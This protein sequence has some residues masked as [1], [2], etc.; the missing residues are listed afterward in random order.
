MYDLGD[1]LPLG[2]NS[3]VTPKNELGQSYFLSLDNLQKPALVGPLQ[4][5]LTSCKSSGCM[6]WHN[7]LPRE[8]VWRDYVFVFLLILL[9]VWADLGQR[10]LTFPDLD[11]SI[12][13]A[14]W[15]DTIHFSWSFY[16]SQ[17]KYYLGVAENK[18]TY[19]I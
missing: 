1:Y 9:Y 11:F 5:L 14:N 15:C 4:V 6:V 19:H 8:L 17:Q 2:R 3:N 18:K 10:N 16:L 13:L 12:F 7:R